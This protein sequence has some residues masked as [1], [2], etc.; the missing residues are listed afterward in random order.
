MMVRAS[1][2][3]MGVVWI[4]RRLRGVGVLAMLDEELDTMRLIDSV[5]KVPLGAGEVQLL[6]ACLEVGVLL[7]VAV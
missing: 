3:G 5:C 7:T 1:G 4:S 6:V 2:S